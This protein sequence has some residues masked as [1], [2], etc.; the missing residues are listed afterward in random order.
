MRHKCHGE[1]LRELG[2]FRLEKRRLRA[3]LIVLYI[4]LKGDSS[5]VQVGLFS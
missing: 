5:E 3:D 2:L 4:S 1:W